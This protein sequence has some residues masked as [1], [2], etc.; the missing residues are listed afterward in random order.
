MVLQ[1]IHDNLLKIRR[2]ITDQSGTVIS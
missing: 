2:K 1:Q